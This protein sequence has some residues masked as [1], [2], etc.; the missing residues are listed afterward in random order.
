MKIQYTSDLHLEFP[1][2]TWF[3]VNNPIIPKAEIL[4]LAGDIIPFAHQDKADWFFDYLS[5]HFEQTYWIAGNHEYYNFLDINLLTGKFNK[6]I[7]QNVH[8]VNNITLKHEDIHLIFSTLWTKIQDENIH[9]IKYRMNDYR[10]I[11]DNGEILHPKKTNQLFDEN[12]TFITSELTR[13]RDEKTVVVTHHVPTRKNYPEQFRGDVLM[14]GFAV[15]LSEMIEELKPNVWIYGH[16]HHSKTKFQ[17]GETVL[18]N[19]A[20]GYV[21]SEKTKYQSGLI[22]RV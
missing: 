2:N 8:L 19:N 6:S 1:E 10:L 3:L 16:S 5:E 7:R 21:S 15:E 18:L 13:L 17:I 14:D 20:L 11:R 4:L 12:L 22:I 9:H